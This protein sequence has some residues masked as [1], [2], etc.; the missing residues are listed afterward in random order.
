MTT[1]R[2]KKTP[3]KTPKNITTNKTLF[4]GEGKLRVFFY[5]VLVS[6]FGVHKPNICCVIY[7]SR[8]MVFRTSKLLFEYIKG[9]LSCVLQSFRQKYPFNTLLI[10]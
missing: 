10:I 2:I 4:W 3:R 5:F 9:F 7:Y 6:L 1:E 8:I